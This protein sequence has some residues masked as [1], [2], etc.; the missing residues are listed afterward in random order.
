VEFADHYNPHI[1][2]IFLGPWQWKATIPEKKVPHGLEGSIV[3]IQ[4]PSL[5]LAHRDANTYSDR[6]AIDCEASKVKRDQDINAVVNEHDRRFIHYRF[7]FPFEIDHRIFN[8]GNDE[9][10]EIHRFNVSVVLPDSH[11]DNKTGNPLVCLTT[12]WRIGK[13]GAKK[14][15][16]AKKPAVDYNLLI[17]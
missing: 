11:P 8:D 14:T 4:K 15:S 16:S 5:A 9:D 7:V 1:C 17:N 6:S 12:A 10:L 3:H 2:L 13:F